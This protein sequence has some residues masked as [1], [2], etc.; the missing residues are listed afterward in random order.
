MEFVWLKNSK[1]YKRLLRNTL[2]F[3]EEQLKEDMRFFRSH[4]AYI[5]N[6]TKIVSVSGN[7]QGYL[8]T[9][10]SKKDPIPVSRNKGKLLKEALKNEV[11]D[12][13]LEAKQTLITL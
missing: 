1:I 3:Y 13:K 12:I 2:S 6:L 11:L 4:R 10:N 5:V 9:L 7:S 8:I